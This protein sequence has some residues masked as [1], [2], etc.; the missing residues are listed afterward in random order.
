MNKKVKEYRKISGCEH[1]KTFLFIININYLFIK[2]C[3]IV[4]LLFYKNR[5]DNYHILLVD[6]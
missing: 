6:K 1:F 2:M 5:N 3:I 4:L